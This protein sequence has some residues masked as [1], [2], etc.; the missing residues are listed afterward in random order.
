MIS[1]DRLCRAHRYL[2]PNFPIFWN[3][4]AVLGRVFVCGCPRGSRCLFR[5]F[6]TISS[7][8]GKSGRPMVTCILS[9]D[10]A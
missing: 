2:L 7:R 4:F 5:F 10:K 6:F 1:P 3:W 9:R 8:L